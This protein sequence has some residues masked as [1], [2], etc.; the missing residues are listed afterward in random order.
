MRARAQNPAS[1]SSTR[2][3]GFYFHRLFFFLRDDRS[4]TIRKR[5]A[6]SPRIAPRAPPRDLPNGPL[7]PAPFSPSPSFPLSPSDR[8]HQHRG[9]PLRR[10]L[11]P[12][13][14]REQKLRW[15]G[16]VHDG[17]GGASARA[18]ARPGWLHDRGRR[19]VGVPRAHHLRGRDPRPAG[20]GF[21]LS[22]GY[23]VYRAERRDGGRTAGGR[24]DAGVRP[25]GR[26][27]GRTKEGRKDDDRAV[28]AAAVGW[29]HE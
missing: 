5:A 7:T 17:R 28:G 24:D 10:P 4:K 20:E 9:V 6:P 1:P 14:H 3:G 25:A 22:G 29:K 19:R 27:S 21:L 23:D 2:R 13:A 15:R 16:L 26:G 8:L 12:R 11:R 18:V